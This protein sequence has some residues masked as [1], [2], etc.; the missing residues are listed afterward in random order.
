[1][2][3]FLSYT[4]SKDQF[5][6]VSTF[7]KHFAAELEMRSPGSTVFLDTMNIQDGDHFPEVL[8]AEV[9]RADVLLVLLSPAWLQSEWCRR[10]F[11]LFTEN[12][13]N[14]ERLHKI[15]PVLW[16]ATPQAVGA[17]EDPVAQIFASVNHADWRDLRYGDWQSP[18][19]KRQVGALAERALAL[20]IPAPAPNKPL[21]P[22]RPAPQP[23]PEGPPQPVS[24]PSETFTNV[25]FRSGDRRVSLRAYSSSGRLV[26]TGDRVVFGEADEAFEFSGSEINSVRLGKMPGDLYNNWCI[27]SYGSPEKTA[28]FKDGALLGWGTDTSSI[29]SR[30]EAILAATRL[31]KSKPE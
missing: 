21:P 2:N 10:E 27:V 7:C 26:V 19:N 5:G 1:M 28:G 18:E 23:T 25:W 9:A 12:R 29:H 17:P 4:R 13:S 31:R 24:P 20:S 8:A 11:S 15:L 6:T 3:V 22:H 30:L 14:Q 16:V